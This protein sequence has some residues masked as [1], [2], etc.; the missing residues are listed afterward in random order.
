VTGWLRIQSVNRVFAYRLRLALYHAIYGDP[1]LKKY[2]ARRA[3]AN[4]Y[5]RE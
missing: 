4:S 5:H 2:R 1:A 3:E